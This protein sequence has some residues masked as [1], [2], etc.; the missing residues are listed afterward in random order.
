MITNNDA[1][2]AENASLSWGGIYIDDIRI[3][4]N[5]SSGSGKS[6]FSKIQ[7]FRHIS[8]NRSSRDSIKKEYSGKIDDVISQ[9]P[10]LS[11]FNLAETKDQKFLNIILLKS[12]K[13]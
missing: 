5:S 13:D 4:G 10:I 6:S 1:Y 2:L 9:L 3:I 12:K 7:P 11:P 8:N